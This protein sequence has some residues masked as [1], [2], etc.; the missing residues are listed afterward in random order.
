MDNTQNIVR[1]ES[2]IIKNSILYF[3]L[4]NAFFLLVCAAATWYGCTCV[5]KLFTQWELSVFE[6]VGILLG[7]GGVALFILIILNFLQK[8]DIPKGY[9]EITC[10]THPSLFRMI[11]DIRLK[12]K[13]NK[14]IRI[15]LTNSI[16]AS[17]FV[18]PNIQNI[19]ITPERFLSIGKPL[20]KNLT[21]EEL[22]AILLHEFAHIVQE[23]VN[24]TAKAGS[25]GL[26]AK[27]FLQEKIEF[28]VNNGPGNLTIA[29][30]S[31]Y[32]LFLDYLCR[33]I[34]KHYERLTDALEY[35]AD[36]IAT[37]YVAPKALADALLHIL[38]LTEESDI[39]TSIKSRIERLGMS[40]PKKEERNSTQMKKSRI[41]LHLS[42]RKHFVPWVEYTYPILLNGKEFGYGNLIKGFTI[43]KDV[44]PDLYT[45]E[46][47]SYS[48]T[49]ESKPHIFE[50]EAGFAY[51]IEL[52]YKYDFKNARYI[53][54]C[55]EMKVTQLYK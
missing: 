6:K 42:H 28:N 18:L 32:Y 50:S 17:I 21:E 27:S 53:V 25:I 44:V 9:R 55:Q 48:S 19:V 52:D 2:R 43:E 24:D 12:L 54:F 1:N 20:I 13:I 11:N 51:H 34:K 37:Q 49:F 30:M 31:F 41:I 39:P 23:E 15:F 40:I 45:I 46:V 3:I 36:N 35:E 5:Y 26:F 47:A 38:R 22:K 33:H 4:G 29:L 14:P 7:I 10:T 8:V 16:E